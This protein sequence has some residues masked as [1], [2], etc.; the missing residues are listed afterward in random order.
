MGTYATF[1]ISVTVENTAVSISS[2]ATSSVAT[3]TATVT[4][5]TNEAATSEVVYGTTSSYGSASSTAA[6]VTSHSITLTGLTASTTYDFAVVSTNAAG[7]TATSSNQ[8]FTTQTGL[9]GLNM[10]GAQYYAVYFPSTSDWTYLQQKGITFVRLP[11][12]WENLQSAV[13]GSLNSTYLTNIENAIA[14][15][16]ADN[17]GVIVDLH[18]SGC[19][20]NSSTWASIRVPGNAGTPTTGVNCLGDGTLTQAD[21]VDVWTKLATALVGTPGLIGYDLM[22]EPVLSKIQSGLIH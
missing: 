7:N 4:W 20:V 11:I 13:L 10:S 21:F 15:A 16:H 12:A 18:N 17:V 19:Y 14:A 5:T 9:L 22:N 3:S 6:L 2:I 1:S 8:T